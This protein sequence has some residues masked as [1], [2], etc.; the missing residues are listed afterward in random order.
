VNVLERVWSFSH[1]W[2]TCR[3]QECTKHRSVQNFCRT[4]FHPSPTPKTLTLSQGACASESGWAGVCVRVRGCL[5]PG[6]RVSDSGRKGVW[7]RV[8]G[9]PTPGARVS[10][11]GFA[12]VRVLVHGCLSLGVRVFESLCTV[13][14][15]WVCGCSS[16][17]ARVSE[18]GCAGVRVLVHACLSL[19]ARVPEVGTHHNDRGTPLY[20]W[21]KGSL[22][23]RK[24]LYNLVS[25]EGE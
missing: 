16:P 1:L 20:D 9:C 10:E 2:V 14:W 21:S 12:G 13:V 15:V 11:S 7:V 3:Q 23:K 4:K 18:P 6:A 5:S 19:S 8:R 22:Q 25:N 17:C 24:P